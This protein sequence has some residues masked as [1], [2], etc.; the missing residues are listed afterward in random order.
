MPSNQAASR[1]FYDRWAGVYDVVAEY[2][3][4]IRRVRGRAAL[5]LELEP[6]DIVLDL[7]CGTGA[8]LPFLADRVEPGGLVIGLDMTR[9]VLERA[10]RHGSRR[11]RVGGNRSGR[12][13][14]G[15]NR[16]GRDRIRGHRSQ[17]DRAG[18][19]AIG[20]GDVTIE[21]VRGDATRPPVAGDGAVDAVLATFVVGMLPDPAGAVERWCD[22]VGPGGRVCL[23]NARRSRAPYAPPVNLA[24]KAVTIASTPPTTRVRY[25]ESPD[26]RLDERVT[27]AHE[28]LRERCA[29]LVEE[30]SLFDVVQLTA[31]RV[32]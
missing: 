25:P 17:P 5:S 22:L 20:S 2:T 6:G 16:S 18:T 21:L 1:E 27:A 24:L 26:R 32:R 4:G 11:D 29:V 12:D 14:A 8:N 10:R 15:G 30:S 3:P 19:S 9:G 7:G 23:V 28:T 13:R 31:G